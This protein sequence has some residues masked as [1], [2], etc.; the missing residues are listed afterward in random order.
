MNFQTMN[1]NIMTVMALAMT[2]Q[3]IACLSQA[4]AAEISSP[5]GFVTV[6]ADVIDG[7]PTYSVDYKGQQVIKPST[8]GLQLADG[9]DLM[10]L[11]FR[12]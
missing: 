1:H 8:L 10:D 3:G 4:D 6:H 9:P 12:V 7:V 2:V 5:D 11:R